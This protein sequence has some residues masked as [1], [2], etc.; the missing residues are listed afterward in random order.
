MYKLTVNHWTKLRDSHGRIRGRTEG[1]EGD[2]NTVGRTIVS[3]TRSSLEFTG[4]KPPPNS[5]HRLVHGSCYIC[6]RGLPYLASVGG[7]V[8]GCGGLIPPE[9]GDGREEKR[10][11]VRRDGSTLLEAKGRWLGWELMEGRPGRGKTFEI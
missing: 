10:Q 1:A 6:G 9:K 3:I 11:G 7:D 5:I 4:T 2:G 8:L